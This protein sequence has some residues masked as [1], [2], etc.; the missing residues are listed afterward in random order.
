MAFNRFR[1]VFCQLETLRNCLPQN[2]R[3]V[4][5]DLPKSLDE[6]YERI[7][8]E[9]GKVNPVQAY[10]LLQCLAVATRPLRVEELAEVLA[11]DFDG[12]EDGIPSLNQAWRWDDKQQGV[13]S[14]C[15][16]LIVIVNV[17]NRFSRTRVVQFA[18]FSVKEFLTSDRLANL[19]PDLSRFHI[20][21]KPAH[22]L[23]AR[24][25]LAILL[26]SDHN[27]RAKSSSPLYEYAAMKLVEHVQFEQVSL[28][29]EDGMRRLLDPSK[30]Y[31]ASWL[32][33]HVIDEGWQTF[34]HQLYNPTLED[35][36]FIFLRNP[37]PSIGDNAPLCL[38]YAS[39]CG[40]PNLTKYLIS[41]YPQHINARVGYNK[42][43]LVAALH[44]RH[45]KVAEL[46]HRHGAI[47]DVT[48]FGNITPLH[49]ASIDGSVNIARWLLEHGAD[50]N[51]QA[52]YYYTPLHM[53]TKN[54]HLELVRT[55][56][57][58][59]VDINAKNMN[60]RT[61][62]H[63]ALARGHTDIVHL[64]IQHGADA[65]TEIQTLLNA[66]SLSKSVETVRL[67]IK[68]GADANA[69][70]LNYRTALRLASEWGC[71]DTV[72]LLAEHAA[73]VNSR[74]W[75]HWT[76]LHLASVMG[77][78]GTIELL[79]Q[80]G[81]DFNA[82]AKD[83]STPLHRAAYSG[84]PRAVELLLQRGAEVNACDGA[85]M[86]PLH[87]SLLNELDQPDVDVVR[88]LLENGAN[89]DVEDDEGRTP[90]QIA[91]SRELLFD[92]TRLLSKDCKTVT[93]ASC[94]TLETASLTPPT[95]PTIQLRQL[96][97]VVHQ[98]PVLPSASRKVCYGALT[99]RL[100][101]DV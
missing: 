85:H 93:E 28:G 75:A 40:F 50:P 41:E 14:T 54:G 34:I 58:Y 10:R 100:S 2:V 72:Q 96:A 47:V 6:T 42:S 8:K 9:I 87:K 65:I 51:S 70:A 82:R 99:R 48:N 101:G 15:S 71:T 23:I 7:L 94:D 39:L 77:N 25:C 49:A 27:N 97:R 67:I 43:P 90:F 53:A 4:L 62:L 20:R 64:L 11:L 98:Y 26:Q 17:N 57:D 59:K 1:W 22:T 44:K 86:T 19:E 12:V 76:P 30:P 24:A 5:K 79:L 60:K 61:P 74:D 21:L 89:A 73:D 33:S 37:T 95:P 52:Y 56:L 63:E 91:S 83:N 36:Y 35:Y 46:L 38:Y 68:V 84:C 81:A 32:N 80:L 16:S 78:V 29:L 18:H 92:I 66:A 13:L 45:W 3:R 31:F 69:P 88:L 55:L